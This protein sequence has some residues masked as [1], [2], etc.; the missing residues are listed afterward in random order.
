MK[1]ELNITTYERRHSNNCTNRAPSLPPPP[2]PHPTPPSSTVLII[3]TEHAGNAR[4][5]A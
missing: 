3:H 4:G 2:P 5:H 1:I